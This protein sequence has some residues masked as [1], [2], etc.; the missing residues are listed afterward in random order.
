MK[1]YPIV[2]CVSIPINCLVPGKM[3]SFERIFVKDSAMEIKV[4]I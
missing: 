3:Y 4:D 1:A 2:M